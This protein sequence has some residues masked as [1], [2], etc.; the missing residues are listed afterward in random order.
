MITV[1]QKL[2]ISLQNRNSSLILAQDRLSW[3]TLNI[4]DN[5]KGGRLIG[6]SLTVKTLQPCYYA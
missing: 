6:V 4:G 3:A 1:K 5:G 2:T